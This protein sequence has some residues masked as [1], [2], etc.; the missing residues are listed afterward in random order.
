MKDFEV[1]QTENSVVHEDQIHEVEVMPGPDHGGSTGVVHTEPK[2]VFLQTVGADVL[3]ATAHGFGLATRAT[4]KV[5]VW[6]GREAIRPIIIGLKVFSQSVMGWWTLMTGEAKA[7]ELRVARSPKEANEWTAVKLIWHG[8]GI[9]FAMAASV[10]GGT[11]GSLFMIPVALAYMAS[12]HGFH[13][14]RIKLPSVSAP[15]LSAL[16]LV[17]CVAAYARGTVAVG[18]VVAILI[19]WIGRRDATFERG[20]PLPR[21]DVVRWTL[22][23]PQSDE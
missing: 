15:K 16:G 12:K 13:R 2:G 23:L 7:S 21:F 6:T 4:L 3:D 18:M 8:L 17:L 14:W 19:M 5:V 1:V 11:A 9:A 22:G 10:L 20:D